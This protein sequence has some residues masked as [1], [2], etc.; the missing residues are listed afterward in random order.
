MRGYLPIEL[1]FYQFL[2][3]DLDLSI[4]CLEVFRI[5]LP[6]WIKELPESAEYDLLLLENPHRPR[7]L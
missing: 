2:N 1:P 4:L 5:K 3:W 7:I 6:V